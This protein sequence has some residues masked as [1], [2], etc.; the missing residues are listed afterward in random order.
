M[1]EGEVRVTMQKNKILKNISKH[2]KRF[3]DVVFRFMF[4]LFFCYLKSLV[5]FTSHFPCQKNEGWKMKEKKIVCTNRSQ[6][7]FK[8]F[9]WLLSDRSKEREK[10]G[11]VDL[12]FNIPI[13]DF[14]RCG[15]NHC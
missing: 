12:K 3:Y 2:T 15:V 8:S 9:C 13:D 7:S 10:N 4:I 6:T 11:N 5:T 1:E 14:L